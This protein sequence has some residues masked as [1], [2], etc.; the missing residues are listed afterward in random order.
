MGLFPPGPPAA[1]VCCCWP[2]CDPRGRPHQTTCQNRLAGQLNRPGRRPPAQAT[3]FFRTIGLM[4]TKQQQA[5]PLF[6]ARLAP[7]GGVGGG[8]GG[9]AMPKAPNLRGSVAHYRPFFS[10]SPVVR[11][12]HSVLAIRQPWLLLAAKG[13]AIP[14][15][16]HHHPC[17]HHHSVV[18]P[19]HSL[20]LT[21]KTNLLPPNSGRWRRLPPSLPLQLA[22]NSQ[23][24]CM[25]SAGEP[26]PI[27]PPPP[28]PC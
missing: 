4:L 6:S 19:V 21:G 23:L 2:F 10:F 1:R 24:P 14:S 27:T 5:K 20:H 26:Q 13:R 12:R 3:C 18:S 8:G 17:P 16:H 11:E 7:K 15:H 28:H 9:G 25:R 22:R